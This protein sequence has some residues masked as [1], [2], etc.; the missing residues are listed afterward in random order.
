MSRYSSSSDEKCYAY[1]PLA[2]GPNHS[3][4]RRASSRPYAEQEVIEQETFKVGGWVPVAQR[5]DA[6]S[7][8]ALPEDF[9]AAGPWENSY[10]KCPYSDVRTLNFEA[11]LM[12]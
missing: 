1:Y 9:L 6:G 8:P 3:E 4:P 10:G 12:P 7:Y 2:D 11:F 5:S